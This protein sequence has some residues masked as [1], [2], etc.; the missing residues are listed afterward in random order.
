MRSRKR[1]WTVFAALAAVSTG[2]SAATIEALDVGGEGLAGIAAVGPDFVARRAWVSDAQGSGDGVASPG[3]SV[4]LNVSLRNAGFADAVNTRTTLASSDPDVRVTSSLRHRGTWPVGSTWASSHEV[5]IS[6]TAVS[7]DATALVTVTADNGGPWRFIVTFAIAPAPLEFVKLDTWIDDPLPDGDGDGIAEPGERIHVGVRLRNVGSADGADVRVGLLSLDADV[8]IVTAGAT[9][10]TWPSGEER[11]TLFVVDVDPTASTGDVSLFITVTVDGADP[12]QFSMFVPTVGRDPDFKF[13]SFWLF[14]P[15]PGGNRDGLATPGERLLPRVRLRNTGIGDGTDVRVTLSSSDPS[16][17]VAQGVMSY[18]TWGSGVA[19]TNGGFIVDIA[20]DA[21]SHAATLVAHVDSGAGAWEFAVTIQI[22]EPRVEMTHRR[23][24]VFDPQPGGNRDGNANPGEHVR[25]GTRLRNAGPSTA[26]N[27]RATL[28][29]DDPDVTV[30]HGEVGRTGWDPGVAITLTGFSV[31][32]ARDATPHDV[33]AVVDVSAD[34]GGPWQF[35][36]TFPIVYRP[37]EFAMRS[38]WTFD[39]APG[40]DRDG[41]A[42]AGERVFPR[43]RLRN[44]GLAD[45][46]GVTVRLTTRDKDVSIVAGEVYHDTWPAGVARNNAGFV[47]EIS[48]LARPGPVDLVVKVEADGVTWRYPYTFPITSPPV[49]LAAQRTQVYDG[50]G[51]NWAAEPGETIWPEVRLINIG[52]AVAT[53][54]RATL[55]ATDD[56]LTIMTDTV[57][58][59]SLAPRQ[60]WNVY[61]LS[62]SIAATAVPHDTSAA[63]VVAADNGGPWRFE[64][65]MPLGT[66]SGMRLRWGRVVDPAPGGNTDGRANA[67]ET[68]SLDIRAGNDGKRQLYNVRIT[69]TVD[70]P[71]VTVSGVLDTVAE[72]PPGQQGRTFSLA[73]EVSPEAG[74]HSVEVLVRMTAD[75]ADPFERTFTF[76]IVALPP[77]YELRDTW[78]WDPVSGANGDG[79]VNPGERV[80]PRVRIRNVGLGPVLNVRADLVI[81]DADVDVVSGFVSHDSWPAGEARNN[82][83]FVLDIS[84]TAEAHDVLAVLSV[85]ADDAGPWAFTFT[86]PIVASPVAATALLANYPN[87]FNPETWI[88]FDLS[89]AS[90]ATVR[91]YDTRGALVRRLDLGRREPG[92]YRGRSDAAYWDGRNEVGERVTSGVYA[93]ELRAGGHREMRRMIVRK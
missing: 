32:I 56:D 49:Q 5:S 15:A 30:A 72:W 36:F 25:L 57:G 61:S 26:L 66:A 79:D 74:P 58:L 84:P 39:P 2:A 54:L 13:V 41:Q 65:P 71:D 69:A 11:D 67:G 78:V 4:S 42:E 80:Y 24:W 14:D 88:P 76:P 81:F 70:D 44:V 33:T 17:S 40:G 85:I 75:D 62:L 23:S 16:V 64:I 59:G 7:H 73:A 20:P 19:R 89:E 34:N 68:V 93:Y 82:N 8:V 31:D 47:V 53:G 3:E 51:G 12:W 35:S 1:W 86:I 83:G 45:S 91:V 37:V 77:D 90:E 52:S 60:I 21:V 46:A 48:R 9:H 87:P 22:G 27:V 92:A 6:A 63:I 43:I 10:P 29:M 55:V 38:A 28:T 50:R 18:A